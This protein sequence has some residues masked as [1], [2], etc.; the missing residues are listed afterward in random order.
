MV[1][2]T[3]LLSAPQALL[4]AEWVISSGVLIYPQIFQQRVVALMQQS[5]YD[6]ILM[7]SEHLCRGAL[8]RLKT[9]PRQA[10]LVGR[11]AFVKQANSNFELCD[12]QPSCKPS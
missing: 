11:Q 3:D 7:C 9:D 4:G 2:S 10:F 12:D 6:K 5:S 1:Y 8:H